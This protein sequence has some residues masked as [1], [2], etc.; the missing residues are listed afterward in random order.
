MKLKGKTTIE[1]TD[2]N[3]EEVTTV[4]HENMMTNA[5]N[6]FFNHNPMGLFNTLVNTRTIKYFN[7]YFIPFRISWE[8]SCCFR[9][10]WR[11]MQISYW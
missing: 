5:L 3:T 10:R 9:R 7:K 11:K 8:V 6:I 2:V 1:L 4:E